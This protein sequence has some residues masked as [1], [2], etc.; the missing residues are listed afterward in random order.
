MSKKILVLLAEGFEEIEA[1]TIIDVLRRAELDVTVAGVGGKSIT[2][3]HRLT[4][5]ADILI[6]QYQGIPD[7]II[8]PGGMPGAQHLADSKEVQ[9]LIKKTS[10][11][12]KIVGAI[13]AAPALALS[14]AGV[15]AGKRATCYPGFEQHFPDTVQQSTDRV[16][17]D[18]NI[19]TSRGPGTALEFALAL[20]EKLAGPQT[21]AALQKGMLVKV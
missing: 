9:D 4:I 8:L 19:I 16:V 6:H 5:Q 1:V 3:A 18:G 12:Q 17:I 13:C 7:A 21:A 2:G 11:S 20:V 14:K 15:L 10:Q